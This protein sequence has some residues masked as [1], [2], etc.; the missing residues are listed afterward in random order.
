LLGA[1]LTGVAGA[2]EVFRGGITPY[3]TGAKRDVLG[4]PAD[5]LDEDGPVSAR[6]AQEMAVAARRVLDATY[7][8]ALTGVAGPERQDGHPVGTVHIG[9]ATPDAVTVRSLRLPGQRHQVRGYA[10]TAAIDLL[11]RHLTDARA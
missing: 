10:A 6:A 3:A 1:M 7:A 9:L 11:R 4:V 2:S 5:V 8:L